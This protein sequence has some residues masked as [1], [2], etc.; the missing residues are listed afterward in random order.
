VDLLSSEFEASLVYKVS[1]RTAR[2]IQRNTVSKKKKKK[3]KKTQDFCRNSKH[4]G[5]A[6][7]ALEDVCSLDRVRR[8]VMVVVVVVGC[9]FP[10]VFLGIYTSAM[11]PTL[12]FFQVGK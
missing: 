5:V 7:R 6:Q 11:V 8:V 3:K 10:P 9:L 12:G 1:S 2:A 4:S